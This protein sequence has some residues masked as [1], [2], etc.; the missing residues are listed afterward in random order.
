ASSQRTKL[1]LRSYQKGMQLFVGSKQPR[2]K[3]SCCPLP[4]KPG[5]CFL[6]GLVA[7]MSVDPLDHRHGGSRHPGNQEDVHARHEHFADPEV[8][9]RIDRVWWSGCLLSCAR[10]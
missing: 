10:W 1:F 4:V 5:L 6:V 7:E 2:L 3:P 8:A 9:E